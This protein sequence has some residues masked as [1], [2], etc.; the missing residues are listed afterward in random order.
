MWKERDEEGKK[1]WATSSNR[2]GFYRRVVVISTP[3][4]PPLSSLNG[5]GS[6]GLCSSA[7]AKWLETTCEY[8]WVWRLEGNAQKCTAASLELNSEDFS[9]ICA[10]FSGG[11]TPLKVYNR[12]ENSALKWQL[13]HYSPRYGLYVFIIVLFT[14]SSI[15]G[16][17]FCCR[18]TWWVIHLGYF[19]FFVLCLEMRYKV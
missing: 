6:L 19:L 3:D 18:N 9:C 11:R 7:Q 15:F 16:S 1:S 14:Q 17:C 2:P 13:S 5:W 10:F 4:I 8:P 12:K